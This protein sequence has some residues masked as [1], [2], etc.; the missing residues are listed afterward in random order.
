MNANILIKIKERNV[1]SIKSQT[2]LKKNNQHTMRAEK[3]VDVG[4]LVAGGS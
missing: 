4:A 3:T 2:E 1:E